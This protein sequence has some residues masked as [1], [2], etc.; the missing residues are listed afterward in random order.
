MNMCF[1]RLLFLTLLAAG[2]LALNSLVARSQTSTSLPT[3]LSA[4]AVTSSAGIDVLAPVYIEVDELPVMEEV[5]SEGEGSSEDAESEAPVA[6]PDVT[7]PSGEGESASFMIQQAAALTNAPALAEPDKIMYVVGGIDL[8]TYYYQE[9]TMPSFMLD[10]DG[11]RIRMI[12]QHETDGSDQVRVIDLFIGTEYTN[13]AYGRRGRSAGRYGW[14]RQSG[15]GD[16]AWILGDGNAHNIATPWDW[17][18]I[19][20]WKWLG[21]GKEIGNNKIRLYSHPHVTTRFIFYPN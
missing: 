8:S 14:T 15:G 13:D 2:S 11:G 9:I 18:W 4:D 5:A 21:N 6:I 10:A 1:S 20:D 16:Y 19:R 3:G 12:M 7:A 17:A